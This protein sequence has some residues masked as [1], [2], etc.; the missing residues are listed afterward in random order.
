MAIFAKEKKQ[1][2]IKIVTFSIIIFII[3]LVTCLN[4]NYVH[5]F[6]GN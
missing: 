5:C 6:G 1:L 2:L 3:A 4:T